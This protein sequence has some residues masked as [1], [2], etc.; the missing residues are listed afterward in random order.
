MKLSNYIRDSFVRAVMQDVPTVDHSEEARKLIQADA[1]AQL[2]KPIADI[3]K[4]GELTDYLNSH[5]YYVDDC[6]CLGTVSVYNL[7][8]FEVGDDTRAKVE[9]LHAAHEADKETRNALES[10]LKAAIYSVTTLKAAQDLLPDLVKY[11]PTETAD[12]VGVP[13][14][15]NL[16]ADLK[17]SGWAGK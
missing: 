14:V 3:V 6:R 9:A 13:A 1:F 11:L 16:V 7:R 8:G 15:A 12:T 2:P 17:A 10:K 5:Y 4:K